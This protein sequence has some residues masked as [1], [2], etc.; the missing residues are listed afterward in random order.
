L[1]AFFILKILEKTII[2]TAGGI[3]KRMGGTLP[4]QF[5]P[6]QGRP[7]LFYTIERFYQYDP[8]IEILLT[9]PEDWRSYWQTICEEHSF[10]VPHQVI[11]GG[12]E[13]YHS[14]QLA[15]AHSTG[16]LVGVHDGVRPFVSIETIARCYEKAKT[17]GNAIPVMPIK[18]SLRKLNDDTLSVSVERSAYRSVQTPQVFERSILVSAYQRPFHDAITD[19]ASL[20]EENGTQIHLVEGNEE[21]IKITTPLDLTFCELILKS[22]GK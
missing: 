7:L 12:K 3:G 9:L 21:N 22:Y 10:S 8:T 15:L 6:I 20:V 17:D 5:L 11:S 13:R 1:A 16:K 14:I 4:K 19:D 2:I 18:E